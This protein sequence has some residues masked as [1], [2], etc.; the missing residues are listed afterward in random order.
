MS[1][2][3]E[4][5]PAVAPTLAELRLQIEEHRVYSAVRT[6]AALGL[7]TAHHVFAV[8]DFMSLLKR[9]QQELTCVTVPWRPSPRPGAARLI[10]EIVLGEES[11]ETPGG[12]CSHYELYRGAM[13]E[14]GAPTVWIDDFLARLGA[15]QPISAALV[16]CGA[17][18]SVVQFVETT[19]SILRHG[20]LHE[21][22]AVFTLTRED[23]VPEMFLRVTAECAMHRQDYPQFFYYLDRH[24][25]VD[26]DSHGPMARALLAELCGDDPVRQ[27]EAE[28]AACR[29]LAARV[30][31]WDGVAEALG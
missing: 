17:P 19:F 25:A 23:L 14:I 7:F 22:A 26:A 18:P 12:Y 15:G 29:A 24:I 27:Q 10:N 21:I 2:T 3:L 30:A 5:H 11:D 16:D 6:P 28:A 9:L 20:Q 8:W 31:L 1:L 4:V 13:A